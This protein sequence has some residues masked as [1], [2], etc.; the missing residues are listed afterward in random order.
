LASF[1]SQLSK[2]VLSATNGTLWAVDLSFVPF[3]L[4]PAVA[5]GFIGTFGN[6]ALSEQ[7]VRRIYVAVMCVVPLISPYNC[8]INALALG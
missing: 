1:F 6:R 5:G 3:V 7:G 4:I 2:L 8:V